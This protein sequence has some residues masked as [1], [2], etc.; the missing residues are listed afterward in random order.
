MELALG[1]PVVTRRLDFRQCFAR[2]ADGAQLIQAAAGLVTAPLEP[3]EPSFLSE[4]LF[5]K[6][7]ASGHLAH[8]AKPLGVNNV[9]YE[10]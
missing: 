1:R 4:D 5:S 8:S 2:V 3:I 10:R 9:R 7:A 6:I